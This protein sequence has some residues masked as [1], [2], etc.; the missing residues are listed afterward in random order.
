MAKII[1]NLLDNG[2]D[3]IY[4]AVKPIFCASIRSEHSW[5]Y[6]ILHIYSGIELLL[7]E[8]LKQEH[9]SLIFQD[10]NNADFRKMEKGDFT[11]VYHDELV[12][13]LQGI[14]K[15]TINDAPIKKLQDLR[16][17]FEHFEVNIALE[18]CEVIVAEALDEIIKFWENNLANSCT[19]EQQKIFDTIKSIT[20]GFEA[21]RKQRLKK[22]NNAI[23]GIEENKSGLIVPCPD[24]YSLSFVV[25][26]D[27]EKECKCFVCDK[28][29][30]KDDYLKK[31]REE[32]ERYRNGPSLRTD[33]YESYDTVC[34]S[35]KKETRV[36]CEDGNWTTLFYCCLNCLNKEEPSIKVKIEPE[37]EVWIE[38]LVKADKKEEIIEVLKER[39]SPEEAEQECQNILE[40]RRKLLYEELERR[41]VKLEENQ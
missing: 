36:R 22:F 11:S 39:F 34:P 38:K 31:I 9:W 29:Y 35:C 21:Y 27:N 20:T 16:N 14:A 2:L 5:K 37:D 15:V 17:R 23:K 1:L 8:R 10:I 41:G 12:K 18:E 24:C 7:K 19:V 30:K 25:F 26:K 3:Y 6:S 40:R 28:R 32:E 13:R 4:K 33:W